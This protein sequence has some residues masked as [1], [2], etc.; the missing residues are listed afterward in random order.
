MAAPEHV[1]LGLRLLH[2]ARP[3]TAHVVGVLALSLLSAPLALLT[4]VPLQMAVDSLTGAGTKPVPRFL[5]ALLP[6]GALASQS[7]VLVAAICLLVSVAL[8]GEIQNLVITLLRTHA[9]EHLVLDLRT[10]LFR[11]VQRLPIRWHERTDTADTAYRIQYDAPAIQFIVIDSVIPFVTST[12]TVIAMVC[13]VVSLDWV[14]AVVA[15]A[16]SAPLY[17]ATRLERRPLRQR[18]RETRAIDSTAMAVVQEVLG[19]LRVVKAFG[20]HER[21]ESR[22]L[23]LAL[24]SLESRLRLAGL[25]GALGLTVGLITAAGG[26]T[27]LYLGV[28]HVIGGVLTLGELLLVMG[29]LGQL[30]QPVRT[31]SRKMAAVQSHLAGA[32]RSFALLDEAPEGSRSGRPLGRAHG[33]IRFVGV[34]VSQGERIVLD[35]ASFDVPAGSRVCVIG[36]SGA[37]KTTLVGL[38]TRFYDPD[39]GEVLLDGVDVRDYD[40]A[41]LRRQLAFVSQDPLLF[42]TTIAENIAYGRPGATIAEIVAA[43]QAANAHAF[44]ERLPQG[45][46]T[47]VGERGARLSG[48]ERQRIALARAFLCDA[49]IL[50]LDEPTSAVDAATEAG[51]LAALDTLLEGRTSFLITHRETARAHCD[52]ELRLEDGRLYVSHP[53]DRAPPPEADERL[54]TP[55]PVGRSAS[56]TAGD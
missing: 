38:L 1:P 44:I 27:V 11:H 10:R 40:L 39:A 19:G 42:S 34:T 12:V 56:N 24:R 28:H 4:P 5:A 52:I 23:A 20:Q 51:I 50:V 49:P 25:E 22:F 18:S 36:A 35:G 8:L 47:L 43:A 9:G 32:E 45:Y 13:V 33:A 48:G 21:E 37:G 7:A 46:A 2:Q 26:A 53:G 55:S 17:I 54:P 3:Y 6:E 14:L 15:V 29:Y 31:I 41:D 16:V 30:Q